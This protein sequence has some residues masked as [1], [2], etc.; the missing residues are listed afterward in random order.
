[1]APGY[2]LLLHTSRPTGVPFQVYLE[3]LTRQTPNNPD[4]VS[5]PIL[6]AF[7]G[8]ATKIHRVVIT[9]FRINRCKP[10]GQAALNS[11]HYRG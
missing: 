11:G 1:M 6:L 7:L 10:A 3:N 4:Q 8:K 2:L 5:P 9:P